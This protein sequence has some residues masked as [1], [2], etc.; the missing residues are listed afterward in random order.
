MCALQEI[1]KEAYHQR[2]SLIAHGFYKIP[3]INGIGND[4]PFHYFTMAVA[5]SEVEID[6]L[7]GDYQPLRTDIV[8]DVGRSINPAIDVGQIEGG[9]VQGMGWTTTEDLIWGDND[10]QWIKEKGKLI[11]LAG[12]YKIPTV[13]Q[14][15]RD[16]RV[17]LLRDA[18]CSE[19]PLC[20]RSKAI[21][22][23]PFCLGTS[24]FWAVK[25]AIYACRQDSG[26]DGWASLDSPCTPERVRMLCE[27]PV[28]KMV[29]R[30]RDRPEHSC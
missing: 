4:R 25:D 20:Y 26:I 28:L 30:S 18:P 9:F 11:S 23:P 24:V 21:G 17:T 12:G 15:P 2:V 1:V 8:F 3:H 10:H 14:I 6:C 13:M 27:E 5:V 16:F 7:T 19:T 29:D 22:E